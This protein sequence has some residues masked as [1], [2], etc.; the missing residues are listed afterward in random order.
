MSRDLG[1]YD[2]HP[3]FRKKVVLTTKHDKH[4]LISPVFSDS[5]RMNVIDHWADTDLLGTFSG[6][7]ERKFSPR[8]TAIKKAHIGISD[9]GVTL[10]LASE[11]SVGPDPYLHFVTSNIE[12]LAFVDVENGLEIVQAFRS[13]D[14]TAGQ[15]SVSPEQDLTQFLKRFDF[16]NHK[17]IVIPNLGKPN[18][19][20]KGISTM[21]EL[22]AAIKACANISD[23][24][25]ALVKSDFRA[26]CSPSRQV[27]ITQ[28]AR[29]L[30][31]RVSS[32]CPECRIPGWGVTSHERG[33]KCG[34]CGLVSTTALRREVLG[35][36]KCEYV[37]FGPQLRE[38]ADPATCDACN[39]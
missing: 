1:L 17:L 22:S 37:E 23:D 18:S 9:L 27:N 16:P 3:Y 4:K 8:E 11:G 10:G 33:L 19:P 36:A 21:E 15:I 29:V 13:L 35:C 34:I 31:E 32:R 28:A 39:P 24:G 25:S 38:F 7:V 20:V 12:Y 5:L 2:S 30:V 14:I 6:E 26:H